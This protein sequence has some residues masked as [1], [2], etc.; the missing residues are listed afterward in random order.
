MGDFRGCAIAGTTYQSIGI[1]CLLYMLAN[2]EGAVF[3]DIDPVKDVRSILDDRPQF[4]GIVK[5]GCA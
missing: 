2:V 1:Q 3:G 5:D 4:F